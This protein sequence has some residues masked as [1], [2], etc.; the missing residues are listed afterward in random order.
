MLVKR[1]N[2]SGAVQG[3][4]VLGIG[5]CWKIFL[6]KCFGLDGHQNISLVFYV[7]NL[8]NFVKMVNDVKNGHYFEKESNC[9][10]WSRLKAFS[11]EENSN[12][13]II[14]FPRRKEKSDWS[15]DAVRGSKISQTNP[16]WH[17]LQEINGMQSIG[18]INI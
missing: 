3:A 17:S 16:Y 6:Q 15:Q 5:V 7:V 14:S 9:W 18:I 2:I 8:M 13:D 12:D 11:K 4:F 10:S 1:Q